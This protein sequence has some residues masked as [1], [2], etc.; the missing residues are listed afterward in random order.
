VVSVALHPEANPGIASSQALS[1]PYV[2]SMALLAQT[3]SLSRH[4]SRKQR[5]QNTASLHN[6]RPNDV[7]AA[8]ICTLAVEEPGLCETTA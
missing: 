1:H 3:I 8:E 5:T 4:L 2:H 7:V 6:L